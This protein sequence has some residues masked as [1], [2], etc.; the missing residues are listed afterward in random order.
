[1][2]LAAVGL[3][4]VWRKGASMRDRSRAGLIA[5]LACWVA[6][7]AQLP[8]ADAE[9]DMGPADDGI[10]LVLLIPPGADM[11]RV[12]S[13]LGQVQAI[14]LKSTSIA[15]T[16]HA[17][18]RVNT[19]TGA[20]A[21]AERHL[22]AHGAPDIVA[23]ERNYVARFEAR[24]RQTACFPNDPGAPL[25]WALADLHFPQARCQAQPR[26]MPAITFID[27]GVSP[28]RAELPFIQQLN[29]TNGAGGVPEA[30]FDS[31]VHGTAIAGVAAATTNDRAGIAGVASVREGVSITMLRVS[32]DGATILTADVF[33]ALA[34]AIDHQFERGGPGPVSVSINI[35][36]P[37]TYNS[38][39]LMQSM[40]RALR[41]QGDLM[42]NGAG[43]TA[44]EDPTPERFIRRVAATDQ[45]QELAGFSTFGPFRAAAP[46]VDILTF[47]GPQALGFFSGTS[48]SAPYWSGSIAFL[49][50][51]CPRLDAPEADAIL[52]AAATVTGEGYHIPNLD[53]A[54]D[55]CA[56]SHQ[57]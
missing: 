28:I 13:M 49:M 5:A 17:F 50:S 54:R 14:P 7:V 51:L 32:D 18:L 44:T 36:P 57:R 38:S 19:A 46:G 24:R 53:A 15:R 9:P 1:M 55:Q 21:E 39:P 43:N 8:L 3:A 42:V 29:F 37:F 2:T 25:Q 56:G 12:G 40:A 16:G 27:S 52:F 4:T 31:G 48:L 10:T 22:R 34:W 26:S 6:L 20:L 33:D 41:R 30:P 11:R 47:N 35:P 23:V 45:N